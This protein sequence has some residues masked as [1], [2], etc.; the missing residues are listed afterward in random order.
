MIFLTGMSFCVSTYISEISTPEN[1]GALLGLTEVAYNVGVM[2]CSILLYNVMWNVAAIVFIALSIIF[3]ISMLFL[4]ESPVWLY[5]KGKREESVKTLCSL[6]CSK[7][8]D[9]TEEIQDMEKNC[10]E[11]KKISC[12]ETMKN[13]CRAWKPLLITIVLFGLLQHTGYSIMIAYTIMIFDRLDIPMESAKITIAY[14]VVGFIGSVATPFFMHKMGRKTILA[15]SSLGMGICMV[16]V[17]V[18]EEVFYYQS[19]KLFAYI[20][21]IAFYVYTLACNIGVLPIGFIVGGELFPNE[22]RGIMNGLYGVFA[23][24]YWSVTLKVYPKFMFTFGI[25]AVVWAF[26]AS[27]FMVTLFGVFVLPETQ[28]K[29]LNE[30][31]EQYFQKKKKP[32]SSDTIEKEIELSERA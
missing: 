28:G 7:V 8:E 25:K 32:T 19:E 31:Q 9:I 16:V 21:P 24:V 6:R 13:V 20:V 10:D 2:F 23:Y 3:M 5:S 18:Y 22:V 29:T 12:S 11:E 30:V 1:R 26:A 15:L 27:C 4:P 14:S 17:G